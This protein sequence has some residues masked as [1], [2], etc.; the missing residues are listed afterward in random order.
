M[1]WKLFISNNYDKVRS[2]PNKDRFKKLSE[3]YKSMSSKSGMKGGMKIVETTMGKR[4][5]RKGGKLSL[6]KALNKTG[7]QISDHLVKGGAIPWDWQ[8]LDPSR[9]I[10]EQLQDYFIKG[11][12]GQTNP[13]GKASMK[14]IKNAGGDAMAYQ[15]NQRYWDAKDESNRLLNA[16]QVDNTRREDEPSAAERIATGL[17]GS[18]AQGVATAAMG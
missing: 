10:S 12:V 17:V 8:Y 6:S 14:Q 3:M 5:K 15:Y 18:V 11:L 2:L 7:K 4:P 13:L 16:V 1:S 9:G